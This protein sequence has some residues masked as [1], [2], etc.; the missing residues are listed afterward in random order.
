MT[1]GRYEDIPGSLDYPC[2]PDLDAAQV[3]A[4]AASLRGD[5]A[6]LQLLRLRLADVET[7]LSNLRVFN[8]SLRTG[9][10]ALAAAP[11]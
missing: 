7:G 9:L 10:A 8:R 6:A 3:A 11:G 1:V 5:P 4:A 2:D